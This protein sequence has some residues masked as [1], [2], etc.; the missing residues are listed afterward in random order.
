VNDAFGA[1]HRAH[2]STSGVAAHTEH[3]VAGLLLEK[4]LKFLSNAVLGS[5]QRPL[6]A[7]VGGSKV[8]TK[9]PVLESLLKA[10]DT[11][12][13]GGAM[14]F[15]FVKAMGGQ[16]GASM[17]EE[18]Q[19]G[20]S[21]E[22]MK[23][24]KESGVQLLLPSDAVIASAVSAD[25]ETSVVPIDSIPEG[26]LGLDIGPGSSAEI[27]SVLRGAGTILWNGP[28]GVFEIA[29]FSKGTFGIAET[30]AELTASGVI[31]IVGGG[32]S[33]AAVGQAGL[34]SKLSHVSTGGGASLELLEGKVL[35]GVAA[36]NDA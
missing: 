19:L 24:A 35:P 17:V 32:D 34:K 8:S 22:L 14:A 25:A 36:L 13:V 33:V 5:P 15:T 30:M 10:S 12:V 26:Q 20:L 21:L 9:L 29:P 31:T 11:V 23:Q 16:V 1:A 18:E 2:A 6:V 7:I 28:M 3:A 4:E 27:E